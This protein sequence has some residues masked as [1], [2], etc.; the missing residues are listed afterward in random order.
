[1]EDKFTK[2]GVVTLR[3]SKWAAGAAAM[4][5]GMSLFL[6]ACGGGVATTADAT[7]T[8]T[9]AEDTEAEEPEVEESE[10]MTETEDTGE[11]EEMTDTEDMTETEEMT[12]TEDMDDSEEMTDT[13]G[14]GET[15]EMTDTEDM[16]D[17]EE[18]TD[19]GAMPSDVEVSLVDGAIEMSE[20]IAAGSITFNVTNNGTEEHGFEIEGEGVEEEIEGNLQP[21]DSASL[22]VDLAAGEYR[23]YCPVG[24]HAEMGMEL[25]LTVE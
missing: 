16:D 6:S 19:T 3:P 4:L 9:T 13:E 1:M 11:T 8:P 22:T 14:T 21:G 24:D 20:Q 2:Q 25:T 5:L 17:S 10:T 18:M 7:S 12:D 23:V 15:E